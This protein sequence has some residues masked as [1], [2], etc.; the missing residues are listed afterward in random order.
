LDIVGEIPDAREIAE[1][2]SVGD[3]V[4]EKLPAFRE[5]FEKIL[6]AAHALAAQERPVKSE[7]I[8][9]LFRRGGARARAEKPEPDA[10]RPQEVVVISGKGG[11]GK[12]SITAC[13]AQ[14]ADGGVVADCDVDAADLHLLLAPE[15]VEEGDF[16]GGI[17]VE[18]DRDDCTGCGKCMEVCR[19]DAIERSEDGKYRIELAACEGCGA[20]RMVCDDLAISSEDAVN[21]RWFTSE[22]RFGPMAHAMLGIAEENSGRLVTLVRDMGTDLAA[23]SGRTDLVVMDGSPGIGCPVIASITG[24]RYA[25]VVTEPT[26]SGLHDLQRVLELT[27]HFRVEAGVLVNKADLNSDMTEKIRVMATKLGAKMLGELPYDKRFTEAQIKRQTLLEFAPCE[28]GN[29]IRAIWQRVRRA[30]SQGG[31]PSKSASTAVG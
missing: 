23:E 8:A 4:L 11:T 5:H 1:V 16:V 24:A 18:I 12:T 13:F 29:Q 28:A 26:V 19:F 21:G 10:Q 9:S 30:L 2:Y 27:Q 31:V 17:S 7:L 15:I 25:I 3:L 14:L 6:E 22:T 20:C